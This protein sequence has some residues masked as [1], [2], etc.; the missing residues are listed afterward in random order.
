MAR[1]VVK[2]YGFTSRTPD[3]VEEVEDCEEISQEIALASASPTREELRI[4]LL[5]NAVRNMTF[6]VALLTSL[7]T[8]ETQQNKAPDAPDAGQPALGDKAPEAEK[9]ASADKAPEAKQAAPAENTVAWWSS[10]R[11]CFYVVFVFFLTY[12]VVNYWQAIPNAICAGWTSL[13]AKL[14]TIKAP[15][16]PPANNYQRVVWFVVSLGMCLAAGWNACNGG[17]EVFNVEDHFFGQGH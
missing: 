5:E 8:P 17:G 3:K 2:T 1:R 12:I 4:E 9:L 6:K 10:W 15:V 13:C 11:I 7:A 14:W 16:Q